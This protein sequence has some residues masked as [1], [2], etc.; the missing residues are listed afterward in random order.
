MTW[1]FTVDQPGLYKIGMSG[2]QGWRSG[3]PSIRS[4]KIDGEYPFEEMKEVLFQYS[5]NREL[6]FLGGAEEPYLFYFDRGEHELTMT[7]KIVLDNDATGA[8]TEKHQVRMMGEVN[9]LTDG[10]SGKLD[11]ADYERTVKTLL[12][13]GGE[14]PVITKAPSNAWTHKVSDAAGLK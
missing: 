12:S 9:K 3:L 6:Y 11:P 10:S 7:A 8:Q 5:R 13:A 2:S 14:T 4:V 1:K